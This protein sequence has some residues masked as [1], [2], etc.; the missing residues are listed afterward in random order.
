MELQWQDNI[1]RDFVIMF[2][3]KEDWIRV[4]WYIVL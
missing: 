1:K 2:D 4:A 3:E